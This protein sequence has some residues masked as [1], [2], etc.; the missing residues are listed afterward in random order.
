MYRSR[1]YRQVIYGRVN[2]YM[3]ATQELNAIA[4]KRGWPESTI[5]FPVVGPENEVVTEE[6]YPDLNTFGKVLD[7]F[8]AD[9][10]AMKIL[11]NT[12]G[13]IVQGSARSELVQEMKDLLA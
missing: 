9:A 6:E 1:T 7:A 12:K 3:K 11:R 13:M 10:D 4:R 8:Y 2:D 5:W